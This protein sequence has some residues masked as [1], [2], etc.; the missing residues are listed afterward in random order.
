MNFKG[1]RYF[2]VKNSTKIFVNVTHVN[3]EH[4][5]PIIKLTANPCT[6]PVENN[7]NELAAKI[8]VKFESI[9]VLQAWLKL[10]FIK[11]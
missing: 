9:I 10:S 4:T 7:I 11:S 2:K 1:G 8:V 6:K 5:I 3:K